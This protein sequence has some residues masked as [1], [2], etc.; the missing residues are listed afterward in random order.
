MHRQRAAAFDMVC[1][2]AHHVHRAG[3]CPSPRMR[4]RVKY[5]TPKSARAKVSGFEPR[6]A[7]VAGEDP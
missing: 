5:F 2:L 3:L 1:G 4:I 7:T 6:G